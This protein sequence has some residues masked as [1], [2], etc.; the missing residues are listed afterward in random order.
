M[1][2]RT[3]SLGRYIWASPHVHAILVARG[4]ANT[5]ALSITMR[6]KRATIHEH[7]P[8]ERSSLRHGQ[9]F[10]YVPAYRSTSLAGERPGMIFA[11]H[12]F[13]LGDLGWGDD[14]YYGAIRLF[15]AL[16]VC[17]F[18]LESVTLH[19]LTPKTQGS[20]F[21]TG[22]VPNTIPQLNA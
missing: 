14:L 18:L 16:T 1:E 11:F 17:H 22:S 7:Q 5:P 4:K 6:R 13:A 12:A 10:S 20:P 9:I 15:A 19:F 3:V 21:W 2:D 8:W